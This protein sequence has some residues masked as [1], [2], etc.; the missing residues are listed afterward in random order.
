MPEPQ[1]LHVVVAEP[2][3]DASLACLQGLATIEFLKDSA[4]ATLL[5]AVGRADALLVKS[6]A[7][8][9]AKIIEAARKLKVIGRA[10]QNYDHIDLRAAGRK[11]IRVVYSPHVAVSSVAEFTLG[12]ILDL[13]RKITFFDRAVRDGKFDSIRAASGRELSRLTVGILGVD[14]VSER[15]GKMIS[16]AFG[17][18][19]ICHDPEN[20]TPRH[21]SARLVSLDELLAEADIVSVHLPLTPLTRGILNAERISRLKPTAM[22]VNTSRG[23]LIDTVSLAGA[24]RRHQLAG[25]A[26]DVFEVEPLPNDHPLRSAPNCILTPHV[27]GATSD[28]SVERFAVTEDVA[29]VLRGQPPNYPVVIS[30]VQS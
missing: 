21:F 18:T 15:L 19:L 10:S 20:D 30:E 1:K 8:V 26:L 13:A 7:H 4:P 5:E 9:T 14:P 3:D 6:K 24:L 12:L 11:N 16:T 23:A 22:L 25:A 17:N 2:F 28:A 27:A 29:R